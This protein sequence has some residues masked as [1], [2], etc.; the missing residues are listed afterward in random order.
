MDRPDNSLLLTGGV[1][2]T[3]IFIGILILLFVIIGNII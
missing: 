3:A 2:Y 1:I